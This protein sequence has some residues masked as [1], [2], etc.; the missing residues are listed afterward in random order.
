MEHVAAHPVADS[1]VVGKGTPPVDCAD[2]NRRNFLGVAVDKPYQA[3]MMADTDW[4]RVDP[5]G[6][7]RRPSRVRSCPRTVSRFDGD[8]TH[9]T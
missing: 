4:P 8:R 2:D 7:D 1:A 3:A 5:H 9:R 6:D